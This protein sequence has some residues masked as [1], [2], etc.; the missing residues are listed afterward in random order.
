MPDMTQLTTTDFALALLEDVLGPADPAAD[1]ERTEA[2]RLASCGIFTPPQMSPMI[3][4]TG[5][6]KCGGTMYK[7]IETDKDGNPI[8]AGP[9]V[10]NG[11]GHMM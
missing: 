1:R 7:T 10:C 8:G 5:C 11:C 9:Y 6:P 2:R 4:T 3:Q